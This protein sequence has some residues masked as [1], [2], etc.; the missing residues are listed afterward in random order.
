M[1]DARELV[2]ETACAWNL[3]PFTPNN[4]E[5]LNFVGFHQAVTPVRN[6]RRPGG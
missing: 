2:A 5:T 6:R 1:V 3:Q 4:V